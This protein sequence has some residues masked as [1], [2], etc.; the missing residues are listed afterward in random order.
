[1][2]ATSIFAFILAW[3][4][5]IIAY[6]LLMFVASLVGSPAMNLFE[7]VVERD[8][9]RRVCRISETDLDVSAD[10][11]ADRPALANY[12][13]GR[14]AVGIRPEDVREASGWDVARLRG[15]ILLVDLETGV[16]VPMVDTPVAAE[17][18]S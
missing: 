1:L 11:A 14:V 6:G 9:G 16:A 5:Y 17:V 12:A 18:V 3:N 13:G 2:V 4:E 15:R 7:A 10:V 8:N